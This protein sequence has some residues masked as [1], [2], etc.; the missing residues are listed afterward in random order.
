MDKFDEKVA[1]LMAKNPSVFVPAS[2]KR[3]VP[4]PKEEKQEESK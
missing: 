4:K 3:P 1:E 2:N